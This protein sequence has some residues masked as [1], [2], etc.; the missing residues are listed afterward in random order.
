M[1]GVYSLTMFK[2][3][4]LSTVL[5]LKYHPKQ[6]WELMA[7]LHV[8]IKISLICLDLNDFTCVIFIYQMIRSRSIHHFQNRNDTCLLVCWRTCIG[9]HGSIAPTLSCSFHS[10]ACAPHSHQNTTQLYY[11][12]MNRSQGFS[13]D[14]LTERGHHS[15]LLAA[16]SQIHPF[17]P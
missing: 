1:G 9:P 2:S 5:I 8:R 13:F 17:R 7:H 3:K 12:W 6:N 10:L 4:L 15:L 11:S 14:D 16:C